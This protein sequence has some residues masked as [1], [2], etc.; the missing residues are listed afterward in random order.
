MQCDSSSEK[1]LVLVVDDDPD[2]REAMTELLQIQGFAVLA[3]GNGREALELLKVENPSVVLL[4]LMM[5]VISGWEF[6][7]YRKAQPELAKIP[8]IVTSAVIDRA[9][10][11]HAEGAD[12]ILLKP[13][14]IE[15][16]L[17]LVKRFSAKAPA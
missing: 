4:D 1:A 3:A 15:K 13:V 11:A 8:V 2:T 5:P 16:L 9:A 14:D 17:K 7:R 6:L 12:E 10:G